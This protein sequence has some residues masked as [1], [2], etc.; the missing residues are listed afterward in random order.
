M[1]IDFYDLFS[2]HTPDDFSGEGGE[3]YM[4]AAV[5]N[6]VH[7]K[8]AESRSAVSRKVHPKRNLGKIV[9]A[10]AIVAA[11]MGITVGAASGK[12]GEFF[13][14]LSRSEIADSV[15]GSGLPA[16]GENPADMTEYY[17]LP[18]AV[19]TT[20]GTVSAELLGLYND[21]NTVMLSMMI[22]PE[23]GSDISDMR[24]PF[25]FTLKSPGGSEKTLN[26]SGF[27]GIESFNDADIEGSYCLT[28]YLT[29]PDIAGSTLKI[30][31]DGL[32][33]VNQIKE[34]RKLVTDDQA[35]RRAQFEN[36]EDWFEYKKNNSWYYG[37]ARD[38]YEG[39]RLALKEIA[40][41]AAGSV[42]AEIK[43]PGTSAEPIE[44]DAYGVTM[45]LDSLS[46]YVSKI[47]DELSG[48]RH[49]GDAY[50]VYLKDG[51]VIS[52]EFFMF[53]DVVLT[54]SGYNFDGTS[55][56]QY[57]YMRGTETGS[58]RCFD[59][60]IAADEVEKVV[61]YILNYDSDY[62]E[63]VSEYLLYRAG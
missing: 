13:N 55:Y 12:L 7:E 23:Y 5:R 53:D 17:S 40:P 46:M 61:M 45:R 9:F 2:M 43:I 16:I 4:T 8:L 63:Q 37:N 26:Q 24:M 59:R 18:E 51:S 15:P 50:T 6:K 47:P 29:D 30:Q 56:S 41:D 22:T 19:F 11:C 57:A 3:N 10:A 39:Q 27:A 48:D 54:N 58:I 38:Y 32:Y 44:A 60:P 31:S 42:S 1:K 36:D 52:D 21:S 62:N 35:Q 14:T 33:T 34:A 28:F 20:D 25:Y 49:A